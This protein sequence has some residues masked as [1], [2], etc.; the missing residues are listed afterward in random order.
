MTMNDIFY[1]IYLFEVSV[2]SADVMMEKR[3][4]NEALQ[5]ELVCVF[6]FRRYVL[7]MLYDLVFYFL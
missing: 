3:P 4:W 7:L 1:C 6:L 5:A 2:I